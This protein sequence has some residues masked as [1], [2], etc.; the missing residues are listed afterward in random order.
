MSDSIQLP[1]GPLPP[2][3]LTESRAHILISV[4]V[5]FIILDTVAFALRAVSRYFS[6]VKFGWDDILIIPAL[7]F[8]IAN[9]VIEMRKLISREFRDIIDVF[10]VMVP[11][12]GVGHHTLRIALNHPEYF[13]FL[14]QV[15]LLIAPI[16]YIF[17]VNLS[18][19][20][21]LQL[22]LRIFTVGWARKG[23]YVV[24]VLLILQSTALFFA[25]IFQCKPVSAIWTKDQG[26][27][28]RRG[29][30]RGKVF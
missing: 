13:T 4:G 12:A 20:A 11:R 15:S 7:I 30:K 6:H 14:S 29:P 16:L 8:N 3:Y 22:F 2:H 5:L 23:T 19:G 27:G 21:I 28:S 9:A 17:A 10:I 26:S 1:K 25:V 18:K 24:G